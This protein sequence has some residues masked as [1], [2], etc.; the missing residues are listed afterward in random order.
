M[1]VVGYIR[2]ST[3]EQEES[4][5]GIED[6]EAKI[7]AYCDLYGLELVELF[8]DAAS[9]KNLQRVG[10]ESA[11]GRLADGAAEGLIVAKLDRLTRSVRDLGALLED[12][13]KDS[14]LVVVAEQVDTRTAS[15]RRPVTSPTS[16]FESPWMNLSVTSSRWSPV[17]RASAAR[18]SSCRSTSPETSAASACVF[19]VCSSIGLSRRTLKARPWSAT[20]LAAIL[21]THATNEPV[22][23]SILRITRTRTSP[24]RSSAT[25]LCTR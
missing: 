16:A 17:S 3:V 18:M 14:S 19:T 8:T 12:Y 22:C 24:A 13:F 6:Q 7:R 23:L 25:L 9:G 20:T 5:L 4:G 10:L 1:K 15:G 11:L 21:Y 2:V